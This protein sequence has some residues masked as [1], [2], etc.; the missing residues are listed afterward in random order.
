M[1]VVD[2]LKKMNKSYP[3]NSNRLLELKQYYMSMYRYYMVK[4]FD[5]NYIDD[6]TVFNERQLYANI[7]DMNIKGVVDSSGSIELT[8]ERVEYAYYKNNDTSVDS[9]LECLYYALKYREASVNL[10]LF[11]ETFPKN[12]SLNMKFEGAKVVS[13]TGLQLNKAT[14]CTMLSSGYTLDCKD[15]KEDLWEIA[16]KELGVPECDWYLDG[17]FD[18]DLTHEQEVQC[19]NIILNGRTIIKGKYSNVLSKWLHEHKWSAENNMTLSKVGLI[20]YIYFTLSDLVFNAFSKIINSVDEDTV[21]AIVGD[22]VY[23]KKKIEHYVIPISSFAVSSGYPEEI[24][25]SGPMVFGY[26]GEGYSREYLDE[27]EIRY[28][29]IPVSTYTDS[30]ELVYLYDRE[31]VSIDCPTWFKDNEANLDFEVVDWLNPFKD[32]ESLPYKI[33]DICKEGLGGKLGILDV[34]DYT[35]KEIETA[36]KKVMKALLKIIKE[37]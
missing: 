5:G 2:C 27:E 31:Q 28:M 15:I 14:L 20:D 18:S 24:Y 12:V 9:F 13:R 7:V 34:Q 11:H 36:K 6:P 35:H 22:T 33:F 16:M 3:A 37:D 8:S 4:L 32:P 23:F 1:K 30:G 29:G 17:L 25:T 10:D 26:M 19:I 21:M